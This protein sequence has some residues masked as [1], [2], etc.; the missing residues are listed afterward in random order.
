MIA[1]LKPYP[2][3]KNFGVPWLGE[4]PEHWE[5]RRL[6]NA[7]EMRVSNVDKHMR[8]GELPV[9]LCNYVDVYKHD[10]IRL[11]M[12]FMCATA[13]S[14]EIARFHLESGD[15][16]I[17]KDSEAWNDIGVPAL[18]EETADDLICGYHLALLRP[19][20]DRLHGEYLF[21]ALQS[22]GVAYQFHVQANGV[23]R[24]GLSHAAIKSIWLPL[25]PLSEQTAIVRF[26]D[27]A[28]RRIERYIRAKK[29]LI[30]LL[31]EQ[32][33]AI[34]HRAV[35]RGLDPNVRLKPSGVPWLGE[36]PEHWETISLGAASE[37]IQTGPFGSQL[38][39]HEYVEGGIPVINP[40]HLRDGRIVPDMSI[41]IQQSK[42]SELERHKLRV[43]DIVAARRGELGRCGL[44]TATEQGW[45]CGTG[46]LRIC[47][48]TTLY[49]S[50]YLARLFSSQGVRDLLSLSS[51]GATMD[52]LNAGMV[53]RLRLPLPPLDEQHRI[54][55]LIEAEE[56]QSGSAVSIIE[57]EIALIREYRTRLVA[58]VV[59]GQF[60]VR[61]A[62]GKLPEEPRDED[63]ELVEESTGGDDEPGEFEDPAGSGT[64]G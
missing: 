49:D 28:N 44:V 35:T 34:I 58:D 54:V 45:I 52:N 7:A 46:S 25:P 48:K 31:N 47:C 57:R 24:Y 2:A 3:M 22:T 26:L 60:D 14:D 15:V 20:R 63:V 6:R 36:I 55:R 13:S 12:P 23:T 38:H 41:T 51:I 37:L 27:H 42:V 61:E 33:Q 9:R 10:R 8:D 30:A 53:A 17:T 56:K 59:T 32:K 40:S 39:S 5:V 50:T 18:V 1:N 4:V 29:R 64:I 43:G 16:L 62:V 19:Q 11:Q 21:R